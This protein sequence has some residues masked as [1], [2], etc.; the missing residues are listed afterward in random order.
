MN[1]K[2]PAALLALLLLLAL[3]SCRNKPAV[4]TVVME[5]QYYDRCN[6]LIEIPALALPAG[7]KND[8]VDAIN[9]ALN[10]LRE[11]YSDLASRT[12]TDAW[13]N[14]CL[15]YPSTTGRYL[16]LLFFRS[17]FVTDLNTGHVFS[18]VYDLKEGIQ[19]S[20]E[21]ALALAGLNEK[22]LLDQVAEQIQP[23]LDRG[24]QERGIQLALHNLTLEG[25]RVKADGQPVFYLTG[26]IDDVDDAVYDGVSG[27]DHLFIWEGRTVSTYEGEYGDPV[28]L[29]PAEETDKLDPPLWNQWYFAGEEPKNGYAPAPASSQS[30]ADLRFTLLGERLFTDVDTGLVLDVSRALEAVTSDTSFT[31]RPVRFAYL[32]LD[33]DGI[34]E[35]VLW[36]E[37]GGSGTPLAFLILRWQDGGRVFSYTRFPRSFQG[38]KQDGSFNFSSS[39]AAYGVGRLTFAAAGEGRPDECATRDLALQEPLDSNWDRLAWYVE[40]APATQAEFDAAWEEYSAKTD[41]VWHD[42]TP[43]TI[44]RVIS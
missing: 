2:H 26:R 1:K 28:L 30:A 37:A 40:G 34:E 31:A 15:F 36:L 3:A 27:A 16:N 10:D 35:A 20:A 6:N 7:E 21:D 43:E 11:E 33:G 24:L 12:D 14:H 44:E 42:F 41:A 18:L 5:T 23:E 39:A 19:V 8:A 9:A 29:V 17:Q 13:D 38:L 4:P 25:F 32:D 22:G